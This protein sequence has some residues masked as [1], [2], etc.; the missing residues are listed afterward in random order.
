MIF[1]CNNKIKYNK[2]T[3]IGKPGFKSYMYSHQQMMWEN[4]VLQKC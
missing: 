3:S 2:D 4:G 1:Y